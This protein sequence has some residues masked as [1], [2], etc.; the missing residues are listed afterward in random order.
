MIEINTLLSWRSFLDVIPDTVED[1]SSSIGIIQD[2]GERFP[3]LAQIWRA[4]TLN[5]DIRP[6]LPK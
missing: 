5:P 4:V 1:I 2:A 3:D 6:K